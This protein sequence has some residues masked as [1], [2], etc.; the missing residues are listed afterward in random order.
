VQLAITTLIVIVAAAYA[1]WILMPGALRRRLAGA[2]ARMAPR[3]LR[4]RLE[5]VEAGAET[6][7]CS[8]CKACASETKPARNAGVHTIELHRR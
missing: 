3:R 1:A 7:G 4:A 5:L 8:S 6:P 2:L